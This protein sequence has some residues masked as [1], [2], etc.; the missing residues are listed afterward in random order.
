MPIM[1]DNVYALEGYKRVWDNRKGFVD[2]STAYPQGVPSGMGRASGG[3]VL[4]ARIA[5]NYA[6]FANQFSPA[7]V[8]YAIEQNDPRNTPLGHAIGVSSFTYPVIIPAEFSTG[9]S[10]TRAAMSSAYEAK[11]TNTLASRAAAHEVRNAARVVGTTASR[12][13]STGV[14]GG[15]TAL[16]RGGPAVGVA[17]GGGLDL[18]VAGSGIGS[19]ISSVGS[20][21]MNTV[22]QYLPLA[23]KIGAALIGIKIV[24]WLVR[25]KK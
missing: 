4:M 7:E 24:L 6:G 17:P 9:S 2:V 21:I 8:A 19:S 13:A 22:T 23:V 15:G 5:R 11:V 3:N 18:G 20:G 12:S 1:S 10:A 14:A 25:G 16:A